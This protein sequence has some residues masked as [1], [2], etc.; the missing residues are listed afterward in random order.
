MTARAPFAPT[1]RIVRRRSVVV[2]DD[3]DVDGPWTEDEVALAM[4][5][6]ARTGVG[7]VAIDDM[8]WSA[9]TTAAESCEAGF[10]RG[11]RN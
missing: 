11:E 10:P 4:R 6:G 1:G 3:F 5:I 8:L 2:L 9:L 7:A